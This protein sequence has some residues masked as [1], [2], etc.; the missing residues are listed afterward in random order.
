MFDLELSQARA[1]IRLGRARV[2]SARSRQPRSDR[3][4]LRIAPA[5]VAFLRERLLDQERPDL[6]SLVRELGDFCSRKSLSS[7]CRA[8]VYRL[9]DQIEGHSYRVRQLPAAVQRAL[10][11]LGQE[12]LVPGPQVGFYCFNY[13]DL[14]ALSY[15]SGMPWLDLRRAGQL[16]GWRPRSRGLWE[17]VCRIRRI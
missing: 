12:A 9:L 7:P 5:A 6:R 1:E 11:N 15:A 13:G 17:A 4:H 10:Y 14:A 8:T 16:R 2:G 3:G